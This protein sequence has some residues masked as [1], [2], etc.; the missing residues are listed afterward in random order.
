MNKTITIPNK[1][2]HTPAHPIVFLFL[3][4]PF[5]V[6]SGYVSVTLAF[7][8]AKAGISVE[9]IAALVGAS[10]LP[11]VLKFLWAP[12]VDTFFTLKKWYILSSIITA[13]GILALGILPFK[14]SSLPLLTIIV[15]I[16]SVASSFL[17]I[18]TN[19]LAAYDTPDELRGRMSGYLNA[20]NLGGAGLGGGVGLF[21][22]EHLNYT[23]MPA[24]ILALACVLCCFGLFFVKEHPSTVRDTKIFK[25]IENLLKDLWNTLKARLGVLAMALCFLP[26]GTGAAQNLWAAVS[27][28]WHASADTVAFVTGT[29]SGVISAIGCLLGG[30]ICDRS[31][32]RIA[33]VVFGVL[34]AICAVA[35]AYC[36][37]TQIMYIGW[38][39]LYALLL[40]ASYTAFS[41]F[42]FE[43]IG[44]GAAGTKYTVY[45]SL[46]NAPIYYMTIIEG[47][48][49][50]H[51]GPRGMLDTEA[52]FAVLA[53]ILFFALLQYVNRG[54]A[55]SA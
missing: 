40:G 34:Q 54:K 3:A 14:E 6:I 4:L 9:A 2:S 44:Q 49:Y 35:M 43:T 8:L 5:G 19:G 26:L 42:V 50:T 25:T 10:I 18:A 22:A 21:L 24:A 28:S 39:S 20:G 7:L 11:Q 33:Y 12:L 53:I 46:S 29:M 36:P 30:W 31:D 1:E 48:A 41:A 13:A 38:T 16:G 47:W 17:G 37:H 51:H 45:A 32:R 27:G 52:A 23:W 55:K 15:I